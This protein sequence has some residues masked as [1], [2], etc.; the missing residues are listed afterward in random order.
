MFSTSYPFKKQVVAVI[1]ATGQVGK[2]LTKAL[3][4]L[5]HDVKI[6]SRRDV[7]DPAFNAPNAF[8]IVETNLLDED[9]ML[10]HLQ[11]VDI[12]VCAVPG[13][14][15]VIT[16]SE[17]IW[18]RIAVKAGVKRFVPNEFGAHTRGIDFGDGILFDYKKQLHQKIFDSGIGWTFIY[19]GAHSTSCRSEIMY[20]HSHAHCEQGS[21]TTF[22]PTCASLTRLPLLVT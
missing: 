11:G 8:V 17:P 19:T 1:G 18:L 5:G 21:L 3:L 22:Y 4:H 10:K 20:A 15:E 12:L 6:F 2:P 16:V 13:S 9:I 7:S 14:K